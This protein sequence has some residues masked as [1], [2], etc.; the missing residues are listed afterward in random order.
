MNI[1]I[2]PVLIIAAGGCLFFIDR[3]FKYQALHAWTDNHL[4]NNLLGW[5]PFLNPG[6][7]F[8]LPIPAFVTA[9]IT[10]PILLIVVWALVRLLKNKKPFPDFLPLPA[11]GDRSVNFIFLTLIAA[12][13]GSNLIDRLI[14][15]HVIDYLRFATGIINLAD[16]YIALGFLLYIWHL[17]REGRNTNSGKN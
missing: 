10:T 11:P 1:T 15:G 12:G 7:A 2:R 3:F 14:F 9:L 4:W 17:H 5:S 6:I 13:A 16:V 8:S